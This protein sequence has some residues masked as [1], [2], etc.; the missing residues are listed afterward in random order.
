MAAKVYLLLGSNEG[1]RLSNLIRATD[2]IELRAG[3]ITRKS[4]V[5]STAPWGK[6]DQPEFLNQ[7]ICIETGLPPQELLNTLLEIEE[8]LGRKR[9]EKWGQRLIDIDIIFYNRDVVSEDNLVIPHPRLRERK[10]TLLPLSEIAGNFIHP[11]I[12]QTVS[13]LLENCKDDLRVKRVDL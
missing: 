12:G 8:M 11:T 6:T 4:S 13:E 2:A 1:D 3:K 9:K 10:F 5:Y 7:A